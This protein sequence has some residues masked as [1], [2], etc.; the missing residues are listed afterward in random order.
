MDGSACQKGKG[1]V[2]S[3]LFDVM[4]GFGGERAIFINYNDGEEGS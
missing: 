4:G 3:T 1:V 2:L